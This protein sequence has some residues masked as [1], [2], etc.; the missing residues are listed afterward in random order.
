MSAEVD[1]TDIH[2]KELPEIKL[3]G[4]V[5]FD[6]DEIRIKELAPIS[7]GIT[8]LPQIN[9]GVTQLP[10]LNIAVT[11]LPKIELDTNSKVTTDS[12]VKTDS[13]VDLDLDVRIRELP[14]LDV[15]LGFRPMRF[16]FPL[17]YRFCLSLFGF[18]IFEFET[19]GEG[20]VVAEDYQPRKAEQCD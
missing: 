18:K 3:G 16:H 12:T 10:Q 4:S 7:I 6:L 2:I 5:D 17:H 13:E 9:L 19:C 11:D 15:Q 20:M 8:Q 1:L 14:Q